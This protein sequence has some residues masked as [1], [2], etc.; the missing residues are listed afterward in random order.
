METLKVTPYE[1]LEEK[2]PKMN[3]LQV[4]GS[5]AYAKILDPLKKLDK[6]SKKFRF[7]GYAPLGYRLWDENKKNIILA[8]DVKFETEETIKYKEERLKKSFLHEDAEDKQEELEEFNQNEQEERSEESSDEE[9]SNEE[10]L[11]EDEEKNKKE[12]L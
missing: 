2:R 1:M 7:V 10:F 8:R 12:V 3:N 11:S 4:F 5:V 9:E 6:R